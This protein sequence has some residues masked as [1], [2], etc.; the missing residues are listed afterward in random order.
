MRSCLML[1]LIGIQLNTLTQASAI[2]CGHLFGS[3]NLQVDG[4]NSKVQVTEIKP[5]NLDSVLPLYGTNSK[6]LAAEGYRKFKRI[7]EGQWEPDFLQTDYKL[8]F[9]QLK[10]YLTA[11]SSLRKSPDLIF[12]LITEL[13][14][15]KP[16][17][18]LSVSDIIARLWSDVKKE[19]DRIGLQRVLEN[20]LWNLIT[21]EKLF[22]KY[23][24]QLIGSGPN[25]ITQEYI[26][27]FESENP[28]LPLGEIER[29]AIN[30]FKNK[31]SLKKVL[32]Q[33]NVARLGSLELSSLPISFSVTTSPSIYNK[34]T[35]EKHS[36]AHLR[37]ER[38]FI[39]IKKGDELLQTLE[40][41]K[42]DDFRYPH[43]SGYPSTT[44]KPLI[45][46]FSFGK[47]SLLFVTTKQSGKDG[48]FSVWVDNGGELKAW[49]LLT[50]VSVFP[51]HLKNAGTAEAAS[52][53]NRKGE[54]VTIANGNLGL[55]IAG[56]S[57]GFAEDY[58]A[59]WQLYDL[60]LKPF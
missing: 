26:D 48:P 29:L 4:S 36:S 15:Q 20:N 59:V 13:H 35:S 39:N 19:N 8:L 43:I 23:E 10:E 33:N 55:L 41:P 3:L 17:S 53:V 24:P 52:A 9:L 5:S 31:N 18:H 50:T 21:K 38:Q 34:D 37:S 46:F 45:Q 57:P 42:E 2:Q 27:S 40:I 51:T 58:G 54:L 11:E 56:R 32:A 14:K 1:L 60:N 12:N 6:S 49:T 44:A 7:L 47:R 25:E 30:S 16:F 22:S 28:N